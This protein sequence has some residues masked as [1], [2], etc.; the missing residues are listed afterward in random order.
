MVVVLDSSSTASYTWSMSNNNISRRAFIAG[1]PALFL[2][3]TLLRVDAH[4]PMHIALIYAP[5]Y[6]NAAKA[7]EMSANEVRRAATLLKR[8]FA[9]TALSIEDP[10]PAEAEWSAIV[11]ATPR[12]FNSVRGIVVDI[13]SGACG[14][15]GL[16]LIP[17]RGQCR[18]QQ[19]VVWHSSLERFGAGQLNDRFKAAGIP[20][21]EQAWLGW[22]AVKLLWESGV[23][24]KH[25]REL[26]YDGH[27]G[28]A[29][30]FSP[31][32]VLMQPIYSVEDGRVAEEIRP[33][34]QFEA[35]ACGG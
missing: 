18:N 21:D 14:R 11:A 35:A 32:G 28:S 29:L 31:A 19:C 5:E 24:D 3:P 13:A 25:P 6:A 20:I 2:T 9:F 12:E 1:A 27:K 17:P 10:P 7:A 33:N 4:A 30:R 8:E 34:I 26:S 23:R 15:N 16:T 22:F